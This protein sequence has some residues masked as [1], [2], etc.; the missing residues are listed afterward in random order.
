MTA[1]YD[2]KRQLCPPPGGWPQLDT[3]AQQLL[4]K[5]AKRVAEGTASARRIDPQHRFIAFI[6]TLQA[7]C[8]LGLKKVVGLSV[9]SLDDPL[10]LFAMDTTS[11]LMMIEDPSMKRLRRKLAKPKFGLPVGIDPNDVRSQPLIA[12]SEFIELV[13]ETVDELVFRNGRIDTSG[14]LH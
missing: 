7:V 13:K 4:A 2:A 9:G 14:R 11:L 5:I 3:D 6:N 12:I 10:A 8:D 1:Y